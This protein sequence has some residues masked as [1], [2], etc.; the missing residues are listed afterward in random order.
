MISS[1]KVSGDSSS[2]SNLFSSYSDSINSLDDNSVWEGKS[3]DS[4]VS[5]AK[6]FV[7][8]F[9]SPIDG[10]M[11]DFQSALDKYEDYKKLKK[12]IEEL[13][14]EITRLENEKAD[15]LREDSEADVSSYDDS[16]SQKK[17]E[18]EQKEE[19]KEKLKKEIEELISKI[20]SQKLDISPSSIE[21]ETF[22]LGNFV[23]YYQG[24]YGNVSYGYGSSIANA[25][26]G[27]TSMAMVLTY[28]TGE[29]V[30]PPE[31]A[32]YSLNNGHRVPGN[33]TA[34]TYFGAMSS[35]YGVN[36]EESGP[37]VSKA[38][39]DLS[40]GKVMILS[41]GPGDFTSEGH[42]IVLRGLTD[43]GKVI[44]ADPASEQRSSQT[45]DINRVISQS[46]EMWSFDSDQE[47]TVTMSI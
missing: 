31:A 36:C 10:Q 46:K 16:I 7:S 37:S 26:C 42:F 43:D 20:I 8:D 25:G 3:K 21:V 4:A 23:N 32:N 40:N 38:Y 1:G 14:E 18:K 24:N 45:W 13:E 27:P 9:S 5:L 15:V 29:A 44:V 41:M 47:S 33:G 12:E 19:E 39:N 28:L 2:I 6:G 35:D 11:S 30:E 22:S 17:E 34:W